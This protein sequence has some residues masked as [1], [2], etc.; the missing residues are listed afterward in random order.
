MLKVECGMDI[1]RVFDCL[2]YLPNLIV[3]MEAAGKA[4]GIVEAAICY[5]GDVSNPKRTK[6]NLNYY[7]ELTNELIKAG[8]HVLS[9]KDMAGLLKPQAAIIL[10]KAIRDKHPEIPIHVHTHDTS[11]AGIASMLACA[12][13]G[14]DIV[15]VAVDS[16]SGLTSQPSMGALVASLQG[17]SLDTQL[18]L[19][20]ISQY[21]AYWEQTRNQ[22]APFECT[23]TMKTGNADVYENEIPGG[24]YTNLHF[25]A[26]S[27]GLSEQF[28]DIK[29]A[30]AKAN[31]LLG[32]L[33][34]VTPSSKVVGDLAQFMVQNKLNEKDVVDRAEEL[35]F[36]KSVVEFF[37]GHIGQPHGGFPEPFRSKILRDLPRISERPGA[38]LPPFDFKKLEEDLKK[39]YENVTFKDVVSAS[40]YFDVTK[41]YLSFREQYGL[42][43]H[44]DTAS[45][46]I[47]P[48]I[49]EEYIISI[50]EGKIFNIF[51]LAVTDEI[52]ENGE[53]TVFF[54]ING[55]LRTVLVRDNTA[56]KDIEVR[57]KAIKGNEKQIGAPMPGMV[58]EIRVKQGDE[59]SKGTPLV[60][61]SAMKMETVVQSPV[62]GIVETVHITPSMKLQAEDLI[63]SLR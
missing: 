9:I 39:L 15:D 40:L 45:F 34:K 8:A 17:T 12:E 2:N 24:Q 48:K 61:L 43:E 53:R 59:V 23:V 25:Q 20:A 14:A 62:A 22:Y 54:E 35:S 11:G 26:H 55:G 21:S 5:S 18:S 32:D 10:V 28:E 3:G 49:G 6:Y 42:V 51:A 33:I 7:L 31:D 58:V 38:S 47:G 46:F 13:A 57:P 16:M 50:E 41:E 4:G 29:I 44:L 27:L 63:I 60:I 37:Q 30:Y 1:F 52:N 19:E 56:I 36:P